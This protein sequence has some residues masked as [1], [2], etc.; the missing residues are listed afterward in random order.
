MLLLL[1]ACA[2]CAAVSL[3]VGA[4]GGGHVPSAFVEAYLAS[5]KAEQQRLQ[6]S[7]VAV[8]FDAVTVG[9]LLPDGGPGAPGYHATSPEPLSPRP[10]PTAAT[11]LDADARHF[12]RKDVRAEARAIVERAAASVRSAQSVGVTPAGTARSLVAH[13]R[14]QPHLTHVS[15]AL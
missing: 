10:E 14:R 15:L 1:F 13:G 12:L 11:P 4:R 7:A 3:P 5:V 6:S 8:P 2:N 9:G